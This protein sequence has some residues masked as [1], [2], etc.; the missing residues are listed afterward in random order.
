MY[1]VQQ[2]ILC[3][4]SLLVQALG[5]LQIAQGKERMLKVN[6]KVL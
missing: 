4:A 3:Q 1:V 6:E 5:V 2:I